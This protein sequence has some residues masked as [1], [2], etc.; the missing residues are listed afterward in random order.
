[1]ELGD[2]LKRKGKEIGPI[3]RRFFINTVFDSTF[4][5]LGIVMGSGFAPA[6]DTRLIL[7]T[8]VSTS[9]ALGISTG[10]S[11]YESETL[12][13]ERRVTELEKALF[14][15]LE[16]TKITEDHKVSAVIIALVNF[17]TPLMCCG[18]VITPLILASFHLID[19]AV[20]SW[21]SIG[22]ALSI[23]FVAGTYL[24][25]FGKKHPLLKGV[26]MVLFGIAAFALGYLIQVLI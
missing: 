11:V 23:L 12:E 16:D 6:P 5:L 26:R 3:L 20:A 22:M 25:R 9:I 4:M 21:A 10:V 8:M 19:I 14:R 7:G 1:M 24:G 18:I 2:L 15:G 13:R 17:F